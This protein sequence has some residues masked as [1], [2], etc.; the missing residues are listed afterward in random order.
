LQYSQLFRQVADQF[1]QS[2]FYQDA[3][4]FYQPLLKTPEHVDS[5]L[6]FQMGKCFRHENALREAE[7]CF[8]RVMKLDE[9]NIDARMELARIFE[10]KVN[11]EQAFLYINEVMVIR[12]RQNPIRPRRK[13]TRRTQ[14][15]TKVAE[16]TAEISPT[17]A[18]IVEPSKPGQV[19]R[20]RAHSTVGSRVEHLQNQYSTLIHEQNGMRTGHPLS[21]QAWMDAAHDL[22]DD[23][24][25]FKT[26]YP[27]DKYMR[28]LGYSEDARVQAKA[29]LDSDLT[30]MVGRLS[31]GM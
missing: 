16:E 13:Y 10:N 28:F 29:P 2:G 14:N 24:R 11:P 15:T 23:F 3:L 26:F 20:L 30:V 18:N 5:S 17:S 7:E 6:L 1:L 27:W 31:R 21:T 8:E 19:G 25:S 22:T 12:K 4:N 9:D